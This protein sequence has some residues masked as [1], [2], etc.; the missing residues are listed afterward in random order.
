M[1]GTSSKPP[2][3]LLTGG[4]LSAPSAGNTKVSRL[5]LVLIRHPFHGLLA[6]DLFCRLNM[7]FERVM[8]I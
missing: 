4:G 5:V 6:F 2:T 3:A 1:G 7:M 8:H